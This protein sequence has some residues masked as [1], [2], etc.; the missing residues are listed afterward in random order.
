MHPSWFRIGG[1]SQ[2]LPQ[3]WDRLNREF[4]DYMPARLDE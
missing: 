3:G 4:L 2:D 1:L